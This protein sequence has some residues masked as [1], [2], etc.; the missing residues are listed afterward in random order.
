MSTQRL[1]SSHHYN[2]KW[3]LLDFGYTVNLTTL[4]GMSVGTEFSTEISIPMLMNGTGKDAKKKEPSEDDDRAVGT[5]ACGY[6]SSFPLI[7]RKLLMILLFSLHRL[8]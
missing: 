4:S 3:K 6:R 8:S 7:G 1:H 2:F 5:Y